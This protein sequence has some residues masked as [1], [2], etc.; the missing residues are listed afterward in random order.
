MCPFRIWKTSA[1]SI[2]GINSLIDSFHSILTLRIVKIMSNNNKRSLQVKI[3]DAPAILDL[4][5]KIRL[6]RLSVDWI[7]SPLETSKSFWSFSE[8]AGRTP[9]G[10][11]TFSKDDR[12]N[13]EESADADDGGTESRYVF[14]NGLWIM[15]RTAAQVGHR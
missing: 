9:Y 10:T 4:S 14:K 3:D 2:C 6:N 13:A 1:A 7:N 12:I 5:A 15:D 11:S 8:D